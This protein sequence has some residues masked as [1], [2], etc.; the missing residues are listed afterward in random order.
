VNGEPNFRICEGGYAHFTSITSGRDRLAVSVQGELEVDEYYDTMSVVNIKTGETF[1]GD[2]GYPGD[3]SFAESTIRAGGIR[4]TRYSTNSGLADWT[5]RCYPANYYIGSLGIG[6]T[7]RDYSLMFRGCEK[8]IYATADFSIFNYTS[9]TPDNPADWGVYIATNTTLDTQGHTV[10]WNAG[11]VINLSS[12]FTKAGEGTLVM[13]PR[14][15]TYEGEGY[16]GRCYCYS[17]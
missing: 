6:L 17:Y 3:E 16:S 5:V 4:R 10:T 14:G 1:A 7:D 2:I 8:H 9:A 15:A 13:E 11:A 12:T